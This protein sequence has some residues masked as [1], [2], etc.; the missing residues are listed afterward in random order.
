[1]RREKYLPHK[2]TSTVMTE[3]ISR[4]CIYTVN[5]IHEKLCP[6]RKAWRITVFTVSFLLHKFS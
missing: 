6:Q 1:M 2:S 5:F 4:Y 3:Y